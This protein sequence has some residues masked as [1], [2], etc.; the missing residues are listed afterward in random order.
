M[1]LLL[2]LRPALVIVLPACGGMTPS[3]DAAAPVDAVAEDRGATIP[4]APVMDV[5]DAATA[6][7]DRLDVSMISENPPFPLDSGFF[8]LAD[9][10]DASTSPDV[11]QPDAFQPD[12]PPT[13][14]GCPAGQRF[15]DG[16]CVDVG[17]HANACTSCGLPCCASAHCMGGRCNVGCAPGWSVCDVPPISPN[18]EGGGTCVSLQEDPRNCGRCGNVCPTGQ[19]CRS[20]ACAP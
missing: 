20:G 6:P 12:A 17:P 18:C 4:D 11:S 7:V 8:V 14:S 10:S 15:C 2:R 9:V 3:S 16:R 1:N 19:S 13:D 5:A